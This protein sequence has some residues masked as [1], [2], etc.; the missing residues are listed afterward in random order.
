MHGFQVVHLGATRQTQIE[1]PDLMA[2]TPV[3]GNFAVIEY[4]GHLGAD[5]K[6][7]NLVERAAA[8]RRSL[9]ATGQR[10]RQILKVLFLKLR[11]R[12]RGRKASGRTLG[13]THPHS[14]RP[15][16]SD[17]GVLGATKP[18]ALILD[19]IKPS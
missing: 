10:Q 5:K 12:H 11:R 15:R 14:G 13:R 16:R 4:T 2:F 8:L 6:L 18:G 17:N 9:D 1:G 19:R 7:P 3:T